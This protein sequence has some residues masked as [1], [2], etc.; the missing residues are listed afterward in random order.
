MDERYVFVDDAVSG[1]EWKHRPAFNALLAALDPKP[2]FDMLVVSEL[3]RIGRD[4]VRTPAAVCR[5][6]RPGVAI[7]G[8]LSGAPITLGDETGRRSRG[9][10]RVRLP[11][12]AR[13]R[14]RRAPRGG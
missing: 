12:R 2:P 8:Y 3:S 11:Q 9:R 4:T 6:R 5:S 14:W 13:P 10:G 1:A 7:H